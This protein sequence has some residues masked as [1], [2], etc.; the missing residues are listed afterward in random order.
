MQRGNPTNVS[1]TPSP[2][3]RLGRWL[4]GVFFLLVMVLGMGAALLSPITWRWPR[5]G[6]FWQGEQAARYEEAFNNGLPFRDFAIAT[7]GVLEYLTFHEGRP[8]VVVGTDGWLFTDEEMTFHPDA[9]GETARKLAFI[10]KVQDELREQQIALVIALVPD[11]SRVYREFVGRELPNYTR[12]RYEAF[13]Q[14]LTDAGIVAP[15]LLAAFMRAKTGT[16][17]YLRTDTHWTPAGA[18]VAAGVLAEAMEGGAVTGLFGSRYQTETVGQEPYR[19]DLL[20]FLPLG[21]L[22][23]RLEPQPDTLELRLTEAESSGSSLFGAQTVPIT[24]VGTSYSADERWNFTGALQEAFGAD[25]LNLA[26]EGR[27]PLPP[28]RDYLQSP[29]LMNTPPSLVLWELP[30]RYLPMPEAP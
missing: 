20:A 14:A 18:E 21:T 29:E 2:L 17:L 23:N 25:V 9:E 11:K 26:S 13:R 7:W 8:G 6:S 30:E 3:P 5:E 24:L 1:T 16:Q 19:G 15:D 4:P 12:D 10:E 27:G 28:M 22:Q